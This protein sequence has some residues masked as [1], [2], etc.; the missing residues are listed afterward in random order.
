MATQAVKARILENT[1]SSM[2]FK[3]GLVSLAIC[4]TG[5][6]ALVAIRSGSG[7]VFGFV[8]GYLLGVV[9][10]FWISRIADKAA[11][12]ALEKAVRYATVNYY[13][14]FAIIA[15]VFVAIIV[16][17]IMKPG[18][19][20]VGFAVSLCA[21]MSTMVYLVKKGGCTLKDAS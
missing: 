19:P 10:I 7:V 13:I 9:N 8:F 6:A 4:S 18:P 2:S 5:V 12:M 3:A 17:D 16:M 21:T 1:G 11:R 20:I 15:L 14:R